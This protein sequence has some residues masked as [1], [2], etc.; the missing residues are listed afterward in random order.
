M[1]KEQTE[2]APEHT[3]TFGKLKA[4]IPPWL[5]SALKD[6]R[7]WKNFVRCWVALFG[8]LVLMLVQACKCSVRC[9][10]EEVGW[11]M[12]LGDVTVSTG[13][14]STVLLD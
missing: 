13:T 7:K 2:P 12:V 4:K 10:E 9:D 3:S 1:S 14:L 6:Q 5:T 11:S 8:G